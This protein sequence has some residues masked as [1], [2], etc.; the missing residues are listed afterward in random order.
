MKIKR[1]LLIA[2]TVIITVFFVCGCGSITSGDLIGVW[3]GSWEYEG[4]QINS[5]IE[6]ERNGDFI[7][8]TYNNGN[9]A[10]SEEGTYVIKGKEVICQVDGNSGNTI[11]FKYSG[12]KLVNGGHKYSKES[13]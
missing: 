12:G 13:K 8:V 9:L 4:N 1:I 7:K 11:P 10:S 5:S 6:F 2:A 3:S